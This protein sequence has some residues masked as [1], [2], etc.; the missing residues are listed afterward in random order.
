MFMNKLGKFW[1]KALLGIVASYALVVITF[2]FWLPL[3]LHVSLA[4]QKSFS[5][6]S[7][8][9]GHFFDLLTWRPLSLWII[10][11]NKNKC[12]MPFFVVERKDESAFQGSRFFSDGTRTQGSDLRLAHLI[13]YR[14][15]ANHNREAIDQLLAESLPQC[16]PNGGTI[17][18]NDYSP[19]NSAI[20]KKEVDIVE[21][22]LRREVATNVVLKHPK[23]PI[24]G[25]N[26]AQFARFLEAKTK[27]EDSRSTYKK[28]AEM[29]EAYDVKAVTNR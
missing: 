28:I 23:K 3:G 22:L 29:I 6:A 15:D 20:A 10:N 12:D 27:N 5:L 26:S 25:M 18:E 16:N 9:K 7:D 11:K 8:W 17:A 19:L 13:T 1:T 24:D 14:N 4:T 2:N 21:V